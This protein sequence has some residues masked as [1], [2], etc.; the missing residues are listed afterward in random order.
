RAGRRTQ[1]AARPGQ[2]PPQPGGRVCL[3]AAAGGGMLITVIQSNYLGFGSGVVVPG[4]GIGMQ[5]RGAGFSL[6]PQHVHYVAPRKRPF[7]TIIPGFVMHADGPPL[8]SFGLMGGPTQAPGHL[9]MMMRILRD[10]Q[11]PPAAADAPRT[12]NEPGPTGAA[13][14]PFAPAAA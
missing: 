10:Q 11:N 8:M 2:G 7:H 5:N 6:D 4:T 13:A 3:S 14:R 12:P 1:Q 9:Q